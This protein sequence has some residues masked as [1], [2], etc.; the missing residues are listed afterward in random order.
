MFPLVQMGCIGVRTGRISS[1]EDMTRPHH[2]RSEGRL[3]DC[4]TKGDLLH[5]PVHCFESSG[6]VRVTTYENWTETAFKTGYAVAYGRWSG[7]TD[8]RLDAKDTIT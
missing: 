7:E 5:D 8:K 3:R 2:P 6:T 1:T 4:V